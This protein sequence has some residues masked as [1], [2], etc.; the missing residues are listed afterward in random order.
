MQLMYIKY[1]IIHTQANRMLRNKTGNR[2]YHTNRRNEIKY[3]ELICMK[4]GV[5]TVNREIV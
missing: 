5:N 2:N 1:S 3:F 4:G